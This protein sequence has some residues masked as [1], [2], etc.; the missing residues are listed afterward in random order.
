MHRN[1]WG[2]AELNYCSDA[3]LALQQDSH[4]SALKETADE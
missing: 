3:Y 4:R 1:A 2:V